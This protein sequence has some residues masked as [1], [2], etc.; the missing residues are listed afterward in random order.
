MKTKE[1]MNALK[2]EV[3]A[4]NGKLREL[5]DE[6]LAQVVGGGTIQDVSSNT[7]KEHGS[8]MTG[9]LVNRYTLFADV[10]KQ[11]KEIHIYE[12]TLDGFAP[13]TTD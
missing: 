1:E 3:K 8:Q 9:R 10:P 13:R 12:N 7:V 11:E 4:L 5:T 6:E 2:E